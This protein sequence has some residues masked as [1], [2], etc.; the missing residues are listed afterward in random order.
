R[1]RLDLVG[2]RGAARGRLAGVFRRRRV[3]LGGE[4]AVVVLV[5][6]GEVLLV[7]RALRLVARDRAV[8]VLV[9]VLE[10][11][12]RAAVVLGGALA[13]ARRRLAL[14]GARFLRL[15]ARGLRQRRAK[16]CCN[17]CCDQRLAHL[18][19]PV[20]GKSIAARCN[21]QASL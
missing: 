4:L 10:H 6:L 5:Q 8:L 21:K 18:H 7:R 20:G 14:V 9:H 13:R 2:A 15:V 17:C 12:R 3:L 11:G 16:E 19:P 1:R